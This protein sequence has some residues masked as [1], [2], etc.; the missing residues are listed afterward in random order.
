MTCLGTR[1]HEQRFGRIHCI[2]K[3]EVC[4]L[5]NLAAEET[6]ESVYRSSLNEFCT[7]CGR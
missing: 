6:R 4:E 5:W 3:T 2:G 7:I 1:W